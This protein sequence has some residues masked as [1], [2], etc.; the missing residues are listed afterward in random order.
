M[1]PVPTNARCRVLSHLDGG[2]FNAVGGPATGNW[3]GAV[4]T[5]A[6]AGTKKKNVFLLPLAFHQ[7]DSPW[8]EEG[9]HISSYRFRTWSTPATFFG[10]SH[11]LPPSI[12]TL[13]V[14]GFSRVGPRLAGGGSEFHTEIAFFFLFFFHGCV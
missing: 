7:Q 14:H 5:A 11:F 9:L 13:I 8:V 6:S 10:I 12:G 4:V 3:R 1:C 2:C